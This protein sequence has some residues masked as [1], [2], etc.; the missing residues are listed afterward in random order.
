MKSIKK[1]GF[2]SIII[3]GGK[4]TRLKSTLNNPKILINLK[5]NTTLLDLL[6]DNFKRYKVS[7]ATILAGQNAFI[8]EKY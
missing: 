5:K 1:T 3:A 2:D 7:S 4:G 8:I 6:I